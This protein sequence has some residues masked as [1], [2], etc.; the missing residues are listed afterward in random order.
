ML[1]LIFYKRC[2]C[3]DIERNKIEK[4][5]ED[6]LIQNLQTTKLIALIITKKTKKTADI[7]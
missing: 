3:N 5:I 6:F 7:L 4:I 2:I 1:W